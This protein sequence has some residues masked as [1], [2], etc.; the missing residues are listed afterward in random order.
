MRDW[1]HRIIELPQA[2]L[3]L[4]NTD[5]ILIGISEGLPELKQIP[6]DEL[7]FSYDAAND[8]LA[9]YVEGRKKT[10]AMRMGNPSF[11]NL[12]FNFD[13]PVGSP[14]TT[15]VSGIIVAKQDENLPSKGILVNSHVT[16]FGST[17]P[18]FLLF[19]S[20]VPSEIYYNNSEELKMNFYKIPKY[21]Y[22]PLDLHTPPSFTSSVINMSKSTNKSVW[23]GDNSYDQDDIRRGYRDAYSTIKSYSRNG[24]GVLIVIAAGNND[25]RAENDQYI[26]NYDYPFV[27]AASCITDHKAEN[28]IQEKRALYSNYGDRIDICGPS[29]GSYNQSNASRN[30]IYS[31]T[32]LGGG[33]LSGIN[34][35]ILIKNIVDQSNN[36]ELTL[37][38]VWGI[39][40]GQCVEIGEP[41][42]INHEVLVIKS[43]DVSSKKIKFVSNRYY[44]ANPFVISPPTIRIPVLQCLAD[45]NPTL[46][47]EILNLSSK[48][49]F[50]YINQEI[51]IFND[52]LKHFAK[53]TQI[54]AGGYEFNP[55]IPSSADISNIKVI[56]GQ[57]SVKISNF[58]NS[59]EK[60]ELNVNTYAEGDARSMQL[61]DAL[62]VGEM[63]DVYKDNVLHY[64]KRRIDEII[65]S[66]TKQIILEKTNLGADSIGGKIE[67]KSVGYGSYR[68][69]FGGT[70]A[71]SPI[72]AGV[73]GLLLQGNSNLNV[74]ELKHILK[75]T[76]DQ[77]DGNYNLENDPE[78]KNYMY[79]SDKDLGTGRINARKAVQLALDWHSVNPS[80]TIEKPILHIAD[81][82]SNGYFG[83]LD[84]VPLNEPV[85]SPDIWIKKLNDNSTALPSVSQPFNTLSTEDDQKIFIKIRNTGSRRNFAENDVRVYVAFTDEETPAF[86]FPAFWY[87][88]N[89]VKI[90]DVKPLGFI[91]PGSDT[92][93]TVEWKKIKDNWDIWNPVIDGARKKAYI[94]VHIAPFDGN[95]SEVQLDNI[96]NNKQLTCKE[97]I[98][99][100]AGIKYGGI[101]VPGN[102]YDIPVETTV[103]EKQFDLDISNIA[104]S[105]LETLNLKFTRKNRADGTEQSILYT[106]SGSSWSIE[107]G[108]NPDWISFSQPTET[109][110]INTGYRS[111]V[112][113]HTL[114]I[115]ED[116]DNVRLEIINS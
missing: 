32:F 111:I 64:S 63:V 76:A 40:P 6:V 79:Y 59:N 48:K 19:H 103:V 20:G 102:S 77:I 70:S 3:L 34:D 81:K 12:N 30:G 99:T 10:L 39:F 18:L 36:S 2:L 14:H 101:V 107:G 51:Y 69:E 38:N 84:S 27:V 61:L 95:A 92:V 35:E 24:R 17:H 43:V 100:H 44:T 85:D 52:T 49:G 37:D 53:I 29:S 72:V 80:Q 62:F 88:Q 22:D 73:A 58:T 114:S 74:L 42:S 46:R 16:H 26:S 86:S 87:N 33:D 116:E 5:P 60:L 97:I 90:I 112:F 41:S 113:P 96:R 75:I 108:Q 13:V 91:E 65:K 11:A 45:V 8:G 57:V 1:H 83:N 7:G 93:L 89:T 25:K 67:I 54:N 104:A 28:D 55:A 78:E 50:G 4:G 66:P 82:L 94:L 71:A 106:K 109:A 110:G 31:T 9:G 15:S 23:K 68:S 56:P 105:E 98:V 21:T 115:N 47:N